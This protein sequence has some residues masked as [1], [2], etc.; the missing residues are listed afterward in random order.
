MLPGAGTAAA[1]GTHPAASRARRR[2]VGRHPH[3]RPRAP[4]RPP[5]DARAQPRSAYL[6][7]ARPEARVVDEEAQQRR[8]ELLLLGRPGCRCRHP[9]PIP[10]R[11]P[12]REPPSAGPETA[13]GRRPHFRL[14]S[15][16]PEVVA[17][18][19]EEEMAAQRPFLAHP[20]GFAP[21]QVYF[22]RSKVKVKFLSCSRPAFCPG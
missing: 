20:C 10:A 2:P 21:G 19:P 12:P 16:P 15:G 6:S 9:R 17:I 3:P 4:S 22:M 5:G 8:R 7:L 13:A 11:S 18:S 14:A 1:C